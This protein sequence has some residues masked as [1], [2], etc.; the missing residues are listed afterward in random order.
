MRIKLF[1]LVDFLVSIIITSYVYFTNEADLAIKTGLALFIGFSPIGL[2]LASIFVLR[3]ARTN[4]ESDNIKINRLKALEIFPE[5]DT[6][7][8]PLNQFLM[9]GDYFVT[10][11]VPVGLS[12]PSLL[13]VAATAEQKAE[14]PIGRVIYRT[15]AGRGLK[16]TNIAASKEYSGQGIEVIANG[17]TIRL[18]NP[19]WIESQGVA[20]GNS[21]LTKIDKLSVYG[22]TVLVLGIGRM[23]RG[24]IA[25]KDA[26]N[27]DAKEFL[28]LLKRKKLI[29]V[30]LTATGKKTT[31]SLAKNFSLDAIKTSL[32]PTDK[33][34]EV[35]IL[36]AQGHTVAAISNTAKDMP[37]LNAADVSV[38]LNQ[39]KFSTFVKEDDD[40]GLDERAKKN[41]AEL[42]AELEKIPL[43]DDEENVETDTKKA[44]S[45]AETTKETTAQVTYTEPDMEIPTLKKFLYVRETALKAADLIKTNCYITY[46]S[47]IIL[48]PAALMNTLSDPPFIFEPFMAV[49]GVAIC[50][51]LI[52]LNSLRMKKSEK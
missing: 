43:V 18:G 8:V 13:G 9:D 45:T 11:L 30:L 7:A 22:K 25:L 51:L 32:S 35:K 20:I 47:W 10:D 40:D 52:M 24:I 6:V 41:L 36:R 42:K 34:R 14:H 49:C 19:T 37:A 17:S 28:T 23:A 38:Y 29:T 50:V 12:Q 16:I 33:A 48:V 27:V 39:T 46:F 5:V 15:A 2:I 21:F 26:I 31:K 1:L 3:V 4:L 44:E